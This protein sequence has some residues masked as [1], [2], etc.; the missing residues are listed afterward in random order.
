MYDRSSGE[1]LRLR[2]RSVSDARAGDYQK[3]SSADSLI[4]IRLS[5]VA[6]HAEIQRMLLRQHSHAH[7]GVHQR[8]VELFAEFAYHLLAVSEYDSSAC[9]DERLFGLIEQAHHSLQLYRIYPYLRLVSAYCHAVRIYELLSQ[10]SLLN[11]HRDV[12]QHRPLAAGRS[13]IEGLLE[14]SWYVVRILHQIAVLYER[15]GRPAHV[16]LLENIAAQLFARYLS[17]YSY[18]RDTVGV[19]CSQS[20]DKIRSSRA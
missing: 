17:R 15:S 13:Y 12:D 9:A 10:L 16:C 5:V 8:D 19:G 4:G 7:H 14:D 20:R 6:K 3:I 18:E 11:I 2:D 1:V